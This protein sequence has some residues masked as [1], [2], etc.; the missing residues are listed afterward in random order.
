[1]AEK[2]LSG[3]IKQLVYTTE[4]LSQEPLSS[5]VIDNGVL[6]YEKTSSGQIKCKIGDGNNV[7]SGLDYI[8]IVEA[9]FFTDN[10]YKNMVEYVN[11][12][13][14]PYN[15]YRSQCVIY[16][17][18]LHILG[19]RNDSD[20]TKHYKYDGSNWTEVSTLPYNFDNIGKHVVIYNNEIHILGG[21]NSD[22]STKHYK[23]DGTSWTEVSTL[24]YSFYNSS[25]VVYNNEIHILGSGDSSNYTKHYKFDGSTWS[26][27][28]TLPYSFYGGIALVYNNEL[29]IFSS[30]TSNCT[31]HYKFNS[32]DNTWVS[33][34]NLP[35]DC[36]YGYGLVYNNEVH[37]FCG[38]D[39][40]YGHIKYNG[41]DWEE[42]SN[43]PIN[44]NETGGAILYNNNIHLLSYKKIVKLYDRHYSIKG[45]CKKNTII[46]IQNSFP[47]S[48]NIEVIDNGYRVIQ[49]GIVEI[50]VYDETSENIN[51]IFTSIF[52]GMKNIQS[53][54]NSKPSIND[55][56]T[57]SSSS[58][59]SINKINSLIN[60]KTDS[61]TLF[62]FKGVNSEP[63]WI[64]SIDI[65]YISYQPD[66]TIV[67][68]NEIHL[69][70]TGSNHT[71]HSK[72]NKLTN[73]WEDVSTLPYDSNGGIVLVYNNK[74]NIIGG[75]GDYFKC[76]YEYNDGVWSQVSTIPDECFNGS[77]TIK[78]A[79]V[80]NNEIHIMCVN[81]SATGG[82]IHY[83]YNGTEWISDTPVPFYISTLFG[84][85]VIFNDEIHLISENISNNNYHYKY[86][87]STWEKVCDLNFKPESSF[88]YNDKIYT[89]CNSSD[90]IYEYDGSTWNK[91]YNI[92]YH[93]YRMGVV[94][95]DNKIHLIG[96][97]FDNCGQ[98]NYML[99]E[100]YNYNIYEGYSDTDRIIFLPENSVCISSNLTL[101]DNYYKV[102]SNEI[103][104]IGIPIEKD[105]ND[106]FTNVIPIINDSNPS[107]TTTYSSNKIDSLLDNINTILNS[108]QVQNFYTGI[109][110][111]SDTLG[112]DGDLYLIT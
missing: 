87:N 33:V 29:N 41:T 91:K 28:S 72:L 26:E 5:T 2:I 44:I 109:S 9:S 40:E 75:N 39:N 56:S 102:T 52:E 78:S 97:N 93:S 6:V 59:Y 100:A 95:L 58:T 80:Y 101:T 13:D 103:I 37:I 64:K 68:N 23:F 43:V 16:N 30:Y 42:L 38:Y 67:F 89:L 15:Y 84:S 32:S 112:E 51:T 81:R 49:D 107:L 108:I 31:S 62:N 105:T 57:S 7:W 54:I 77:S 11:L 99:V 98:N 46:N 60:A 19:S 4:E 8:D 90:E 14:I 76:H 79:V 73:N 104:K 55:S 82:Y 34:S 61:T 18:E 48:N 53:Q 12:T 1:M 69:L 27:V 83:K 24:P 22:V 111:P 65:P 63:I 47:I 20:S 35:Y 10:G 25:A 86:S 85:S 74:L 96:G 17:N 45:Y 92:P 106:N 71:K 110:T 3:K 88:V 70:G 94:V 21:I 66:R 50:G 36:S